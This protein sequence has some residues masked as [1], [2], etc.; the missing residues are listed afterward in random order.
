MVLQAGLEPA[1]PGL[2]ILSSIHLSYWSVN[3][4]VCENTLLPPG[5]ARII[6]D[7]GNFTPNTNQPN[8]KQ[9]L[10]VISSISSVKFHYSFTKSRTRKHTY[11]TKM[12]LKMLETRNIKRNIT[13]G[14]PHRFECSDQ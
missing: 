9:S 6:S 7:S 8:S 10:I 1:A 5:N 3:F 2:G 11:T 12:M 13:L 4:R 14:E